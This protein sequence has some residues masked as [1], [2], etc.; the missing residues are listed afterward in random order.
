MGNC[1]KSEKNVRKVQKIVPTG[2]ETLHMVAVV[3]N[4]AGFNTRKE[5]YKKFEKELFLNVSNTKRSSVILWTIECLFPGQTDYSVTDSRNPYHI[6]VR[7]PHKIWLKENLINLAVK[8]FPSD[9]QYMAW[10]DA[11]IIFEQ[12]EVADRTIAALKISPVV[13]MFEDINFLGP[14]NEILETNKSFGYFCQNTRA[15]DVANFDKAYPHPGFA[16]AM[17]RTAYKM[18]NGLPDFSIVGNCDNH[19]AYAMLGRVDESIPEAA[20]GYVSVGYRN[21]LHGMQSALMSMQR[22]LASGQRLGP[23]Y[24]PGMKI[25]HLW[26]GDWRDRGYVTRWACLHVQ[27]TTFD[28]AEHLAR[29]DG[30]LV[31]KDRRFL[32]PIE[33]YFTSRKEDSKQVV[34]DHK[35]KHSTAAKLEPLHQRKQLPDGNERRALEPVQ[36]VRIPQEQ[37]QKPAPVVTRHTKTTKHQQGKQRNEKH[38]RHR[39]DKHYEDDECD[40]YHHEDGHNGNG[41]C[42]DGPSHGHGGGLHNHFSGH[43]HDE[44]SHGH[45]YG[46]NDNYSSHCHDVGGHGTT[47]GHDIFSAGHSA[48]C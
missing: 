11:D 8:Q 1:I 32:E 46:H 37:K 34:T 42:H 13:Q 9:W 21:F 38:R 4:P 29:D 7:A 23:G 26:H 25:R 31:L 19:F 18:V 28:P 3:F 17:T 45:G 22:T 33:R 39:E 41:H 30:M 20:W 35:N 5:L 12:Y 15:I 43:C 2:S 10:V 47:T 6:Q 48:Y 36:R 40:Y 27:G 24:V 44:P 14:D 16:W